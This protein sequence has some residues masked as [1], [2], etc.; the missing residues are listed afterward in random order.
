MAKGKTL[1]RI[2]PAYSPDFSF[3]DRHKGLV[4]GLDE[5]G[6]GPLA[7]PVVAAAVIIRRAEMPD[8]IL[9]Q[10]NDS[11][12]LTGAKRE[13]LYKQIHEYSYVSVG[14]CEVE[15]IDRLNILQASLLA[16]RKAHVKLLKL[17]DAPPVAAL[18]DG[19][20]KAKLGGSIEEIT[21]VKGDARSYSIAAAS[22]IAKHHR[23]EIMKKHAEQFPQYGWARNAGYGTAMHLE[24]LEKHGVTPQHRRSFSPVAERLV[25]QSSANN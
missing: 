7:G 9:K 22:I 6:R 2:I 18:I 24:A 12:K 15:E 8:A 13:F 17:V 3:E 14:V 20:M 5:A 4:C 1:T 21:I 11:K 23:D 10:I 19:N 25:K 16:M